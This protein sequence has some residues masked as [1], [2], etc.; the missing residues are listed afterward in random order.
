MKKFFVFAALILI[1]ATVVF[2]Q[3]WTSVPAPVVDPGPPTADEIFNNR[4]NYYGMS[5]SGLGFGNASPQNTSTAGR[6]RSAADNYIRPDSFAGVS[7]EKFYAMAS[8]ANAGKANLGFATKIGTLYLAAAYAGSF[9]TGYSTFPY[10]EVKEEH[11]GANTS[12]PNGSEKTVP[13]YDF[14]HTDP[15]N[16]KKTDN[17]VGLLI[18]LPS[19]NMGFQVSYTS[20]DHEWK[21]FKDIDAKASITPPPLVVLQQQI[22]N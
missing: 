9:W 12:D 4:F 7:F 22:S 19:A 14:N 20:T 10:Q 11:W 6:F 5:T 1:S 2:A 13:G 17:R 18:G 8:F 16:G 15:F 21:T 3:S